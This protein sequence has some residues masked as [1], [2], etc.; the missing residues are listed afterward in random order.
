VTRPV[1][2]QDVQQPSESVSYVD[3]LHPVFKLVFSSVLAITLLSLVL[4][5]ILVLLIQQPSDEARS[6]MDACLTI[7]KTG[8]GTF[9]GLVGGSATQMMQQRIDHRG[10]SRRGTVNRRAAPGS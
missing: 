3:R 7:V 6:L 8:F 9:V 1:R 10:A 5:L 2:G 4:D